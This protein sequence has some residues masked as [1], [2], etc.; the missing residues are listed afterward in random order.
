MDFASEMASF[1]SATHPS[2]VMGFIHNLPLGL[3]RSTARFCFVLLLHG[4]Q[5]VEIAFFSEE[6]TVDPRMRTAMHKMQCQT[7]LSICRCIH[8]GTGNADTERWG[9]GWRRERDTHTIV[10][11][12]GQ[13]LCLALMISI[14]THTSRPRPL[15][16][17]LSPPGHK[18]LRSCFSNDTTIC[19]CTL[20]TL[21][22]LAILAHKIISELP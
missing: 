12:D 16:A 14:C 15:P 7:S 10:R 1:I 11:T 5:V 17:H 8:T 13:T 21:E 9:C 18:K 6:M 20:L 19:R 22:S 2:L 4:A 3:T